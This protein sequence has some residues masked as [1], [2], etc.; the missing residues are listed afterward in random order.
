MSYVNSKI[1][2][3][4]A[5]LFIIYSYRLFTRKSLSLTGGFPLFCLR[6]EKQL[7]TE[8]ELFLI[9]ENNPTIT[10]RKPSPTT[11]TAAHRGDSDMLYYRYNVTKWEKSSK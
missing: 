5:H 2:Y 6:T 4:H 9:G 8:K 1:R 7:Q 11:P 3:A 10:E